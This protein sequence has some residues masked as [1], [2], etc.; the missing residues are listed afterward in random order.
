MKKILSLLTLLLCIASGAW[1]DT[2]T[3]F[4]AVAKAELTVE[5]NATD[6][7]ISS[8]YA[9]VSG[10][11]IFVT[12]GQTSEKK[13]IAKNSNSCRFTFTNNNTFFKVDLDEALEAGDVITVNFQGGVKNDLN[14]GVWIS[15]SESYPSS[16][17]ACAITSESTSYQDGTYTVT[18]S[19]EYVGQKTLYIFRSAGATTYMTSFVVTRTL[20]ATAPT[21]TTQ[22]VSASYKQ[23]ATATALAVEAI[24]SSG[25][26]SYQWYS[27]SSESTEGATAIDGATSASYTPS[28]ATLGTTYYYCKVSDAQGSTN[29]I[30]AC[31]IVA[32]TSIVGY[33]EAISGTTLLARSLTSEDANI[34]ISDPIFGSAITD[35]GSKTVYIDNT[36][37]TNTKSWRKSISDY[38]NQY[39]GYTL[40]VASGYKMNI[41][42]VNA[43]IAVAD[44]TY[45][46]YVEILNAGGEQVWKSGERTTLKASS[47]KID[48]V[49][50]ST[51]ETVQGLTGNVTVK[52]WVKQ[53]GSTKY[54]SINY[55][56]LTV[57]TDID[58]RPTYAMSVSFDET[59]GS[60]T[61]ADGA[62]ITEGE[63]V[64]FTATPNLG[65]KFVK[66]TID[67]T[68]YTEN[69]YTIENVTATHTAVATFG[70]L[71]KV[72][73]DLGDYAGTVNKVLNN[74]AFGEVYADADGKYTIPSYAHRYLYREGY[75]LSG[76]SDG[77]NTYE[78][79]DELTIT[80]DITLTPTWTATTQS[81]A[82]SDSEV[83]VT[84]NLRHSQIL[85]NAW[86]G[87]D[88]V[89]Y[90]TKPQTI[91]GETIAIPMIVDATN[92]KIDNS[93]RKDNDNAQVNKGTK[94]TI[95][96]IPGMIIAITDANTNFTTTTIAGT[97]EYEG[98]GTKSISYTYTGTDE[99]IDIVIDETNQ[100]LK[101]I[102]VTYPKMK[103]ATITTANY[104][105]FI[106]TMK[107]AVP[108]EVKAYYVNEIKNGKA[109]MKEVTVIPANTPVII[110]KEVD[111][112]TRVFFAPTD[113]DASKVEG[114]LLN[115]SD[116]ETVADG[117]QYILANGEDGVGFYKAKEESTIPARKAYLVSPVGANF[118]SFSFDGDATGIEKVENAAVNANGTMF[119]LAGQRVAQPTKGLYIVNGKKV[120]VK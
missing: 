21:I 79:G 18:A 20:A 97:T 80:E 106:P 89:G 115:Y 107:V 31:I 13:L 62:E 40:T 77:T 105:T 36:A 42:N 86:Q 27:N 3:V 22:P 61:P 28:T 44:D 110:Y 73:Y 1:A 63:N 71:N 102:A 19:D 59:M 50:I 14:K 111:T 5:A 7:E 37:Y 109:Q 54:F 24:A 68:D 85:F 65:Y 26:L 38:T 96:A 23:N 58:D 83:T 84:W 46:W 17:P 49:D 117:T 94:F 82:N 6:F 15:T 87:T 91:N 113:D 57:D 48:N 25:T 92:G 76:W 119:N 100:Y 4:S 93:G 55:L 114:N 75:M 41:R 39:V 33:T 99:T 34:T 60:V 10:G 74:A 90:Y 45:T 118:L 43:R 47:A 8:T 32:N 112:D 35:Q 70:A 53:G 51:T 88:A 72:T 69:P 16:A 2:E 12:N 52:L 67:G 11:K 29:S 104:A 81:L 108:D 120:V 116:A 101:T 64:T 103:S 98:N 30:F 95:P 56:Q 66:W 9:T 78:T